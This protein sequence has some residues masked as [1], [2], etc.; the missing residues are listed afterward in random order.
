MNLKSVLSEK[1][2][3]IYIS[4]FFML[5]FSCL[6]LLS[7]A[8]EVVL[9]GERVGFV[10]NGYIIEKEI[11]GIKS[12]IEKDLESSIIV[13]NQLKYNR[14]IVLK[15]NI[16]GVKDIVSIYKE[17]LNYKIDGSVIEV[18]G[19][20]IISLKSEKD[21]KDMLDKI[22]ENYI[23]KG[24]LLKKATF[25]EDVK[26]KKKELDKDEIT[27]KDDG[28]KELLTGG[29]ETKVHKVKKGDTAWDIA[30]AN[31]MSIEEI[32][33]ANKGINIAILQIGQELNLSKAN[34][35]VHVETIELASYEEEIPYEIVYEKSPALDMGDKLIKEEGIKGKKKIEAEIVK[36]NGIIKV[37]NIINEEIIEKPKN[38]IVI[39]GTKLKTF[40]IAAGSLLKPTRGRVTSRYGKRWGKHHKGVDIGAAIGTPIKATGG[41]KVVYSGW[42]NGY[43]K[44]IILDHGNGFQSYYA[45]C[46]SLKAKVGEYVKKGEVIATVGKTGRVTGPHLHF[47]VRKNGVAIDPLNYVKY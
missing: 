31:N 4:I 30:I 5:L 28:I 8:Y 35:Y 40:T 6:G 45:H 47:E 11:K 43:G 29:I 9:D 33:K 27:S 38:M 37:K 25:V 44:I 20:E 1:N 17:K 15:K 7:T 16:N 21:A 18:D 10:E 22:K 36:M 2:K 3:V 34:A 19:K 39:K 42:K 24:N 32:E 26:I 13:K 41:G 23:S 12:D 14:V 46:N